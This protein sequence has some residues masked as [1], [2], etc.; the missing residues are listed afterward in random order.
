MKIWKCVQH[1][2]DYPGR[3]YVWEFGE[4]REAIVTRVQGMKRS[5]R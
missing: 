5:R 1:T 3:E 2:R 4:W